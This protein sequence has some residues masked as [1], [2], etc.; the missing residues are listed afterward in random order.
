MA[1][2]I[3]F[4]KEN[5]ELSKILCPTCHK[6]EKQSRVYLVDHANGLQCSK[7]Q[8]HYFELDD[9]IN[10]TLYVFKEEE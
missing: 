2:D 4:L 5:A 6:E 10:V 3:D 7:I 1:L 8:A 9:L